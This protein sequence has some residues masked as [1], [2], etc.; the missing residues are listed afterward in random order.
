AAFDSVFL[1]L[2]A[3]GDLWPQPH[4]AALPDSLAGAPN[5]D[6]QPLSDRPGCADRRRRRR[7]DWWRVC[8]RGRHR[9]A[10]GRPNHEAAGS[11]TLSPLPPGERGWGRGPEISDQHGTSYGPENS[12]PLPNPLPRRERGIVKCKVTTSQPIAPISATAHNLLSF[13]HW[14]LDMAHMGYS[15]QQLRDILSNTK[16]DRKSVV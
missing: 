15:D 9:R 8:R 11:L 12:R 14:S 2:S 7:L 10:E 3:G 1:P 5:A 13:C 16:T 6:S 4:P